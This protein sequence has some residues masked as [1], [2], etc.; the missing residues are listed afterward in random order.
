M[1]KT[2]HFYKKLTALVVGGLLSMSLAGTA[3][4]ADAVD[5]NLEDSVQMAMENNRTIKQSMTDVDTAQWSLKSARASMGPSI[6]LSSSANRIGGKLYDSYKASAS[7]TGIDYNY[8]F[9]NSVSASIPLY[10]GGQLERN[11]DAAR[12]G[13]NS[14]DLTLENAKQTIR[15]NTT[16]GYFQILEDRSLVGV[17][18]ESV[19]NLQAH[20]DNVNAQYRVGTVAKSD[21][22]SSQVNLANAQQSLVTAQNNYDVAVAKL[23]NLIGLPTDT[24]LNIKDDLKYTKYDLTQDDCTQYALQHRPD[25]IA[26]DYSVKQA[27]AAVEAA[28]A[29]NRPKVTASASDQIGGEHPFDDNHT[30]SDTWSMGVN[31]SWNVF[32]NHVTDA[33]VHEKEAALEKVRQAAAATKETIALD[34]RTAYLSLVAAEKNIQTMQV[35]VEKA[36]EDNKIAQVRYSAGVGTNLDVMDANEKLTTAQTSYYTALYTYNT[37]KAAL[38]KAMGIPVDLDVVKYQQDAEKLAKRSIAK[39]VESKT[40]V[41]QEK[42]KPEAPVVQSNKVKAA[43]QPAAKENA[44]EEAAAVSSELG[45]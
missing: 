28:K 36:Q 10:S 34:V 5:L 22:L 44:A 37:S 24:V 12:Y 23:N 42:V 8:A 21:V 19:D 39:K 4:A 16:A 1:K 17:Q 13:V 3:M 41:K 31:A 27:E 9:T 40:S 15:Y 29:G 11:V 32:D 38:D 25:G 20:L 6:T 18:Q 30:G 14:A 7:L 33:V 35:T 45:K 26:A 43:A 2:S